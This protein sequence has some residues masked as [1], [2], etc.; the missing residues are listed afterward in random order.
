MKIN[1]SEARDIARRW[2]QACGSDPLTAFA[3]TGLI[4]DRKKLIAALEGLRH[5]LKHPV[6]IDRLR[7][8]VE[9]PPSPAEVA[10]RHAGWSADDHAIYHVHDIERSVTY[11]SW[12]ACCEGE[13]IVPAVGVADE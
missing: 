3:G 8:Y 5:F 1:D 13:D 7:A 4:A 11:K 6:E 2:G 9:E 12:E 10:A